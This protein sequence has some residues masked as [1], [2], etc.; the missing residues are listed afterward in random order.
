M[1]TPTDIL[2]KVG[3][4]VGAEIKTLTGTIANTYATQ[5][6]LQAVSNTLA[7]YKSDS[8]DFW[9]YYADETELNDNYI[10]GGFAHVHGTGYA[11][12]GHNDAWVKLAK[13]SESATKSELTNGLNLKADQTSLDTTN[14]NLSNL[15]D[16]TTSATL[17]KATEAEFGSLKVTGD[18]IVTNTETIEVSDNILELNKAESGG[19]TAS[20]SGISINR[21]SETDLSDPDNPVVTDKPSATFLWVDNDSQFQVK[22]GTALADLKADDI[23]SSTINVPSGVGVTINGVALGDYATF[24]S[25]FNTALTA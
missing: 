3:Q 14:T 10:H 2:G 23:T 22:V 12:F 16:G 15:M 17:L 11:Y 1:S 18:T 9:V 6:A 5:T 7:N 20:T 25:A 4:K 19:T 21:G 8:S 24:E 13:F